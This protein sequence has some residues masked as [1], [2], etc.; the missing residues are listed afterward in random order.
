MDDY[1][2]HGQKT[3]SL[4]NVVLSE[5]AEN[6]VDGEGFKQRSFR[7][8]QNQEKIIQHHTNKKTTIFWAH[9]PPEWRHTAPHSFG[10]KG[11]RLEGT[12]E[13]KNEVDNKHH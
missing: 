8:S 4:Q 5:N 7:K 1:R 9:H 10:W 3:F 12:R 2:K 6:I 13:T 11:E